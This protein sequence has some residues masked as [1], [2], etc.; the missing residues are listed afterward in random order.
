MQPCLCKKHF[1]EVANYFDKEIALAYDVD[2]TRCVICN[3]VIYLEGARRF[4]HATQLNQS[5][6]TLR[7]SD[8]FAQHGA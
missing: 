6:E 2:E 4:V 3:K 8:S 7:L 5:D 1:R